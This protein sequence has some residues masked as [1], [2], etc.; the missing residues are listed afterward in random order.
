MLSIQGKPGRLCDTLSRRELLTVGTVGLLGLTLPDVLRHEAG[1]TGAS[2]MAPRS[3]GFGRAKSLIFLYLQGSPSHIDTWDPKPAAPAEYRG[4]FQ[5]IA[6]TAPG[7]M[8]SEGSCQFSAGRCRA[9]KGRSP[10]L[11][12]SWDKVPRIL[13][14][15]ENWRS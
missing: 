11:A 15:L 6:T 7:M 5:P 9:T 10:R 4:E 13:K 2:P 3:A 14:N 1:A 12:A 8:L